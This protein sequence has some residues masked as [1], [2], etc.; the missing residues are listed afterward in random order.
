MSTWL[1]M[2][3]S[4][5]ARIESL[6]VVGDIPV[7]VDRQKSVTTLVASAVGKSKGACVTILWHMASFDPDADPMVTSPSYTIRV[8]ALPVITDK[9]IEAV[10]ADDLVEAILPALNDWHPNPNAQ[11][12]EHWV[13]GQVN[14]LPDKVYL[15][16]EF[17]LTARTTL[18]QPEF[19]PT[20]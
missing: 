16:Y 6:T 2:A 11:Y 17:P 20:P 5:A 12:D 3:E 1:D 7:I 4:I 15:I 8:Y 9:H 18:P 19:K 10:K 14:L 13:A